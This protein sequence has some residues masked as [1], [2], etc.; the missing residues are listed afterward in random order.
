MKRYWDLWFQALFLQQPAFDE[1]SRERYAFAHGL[2]FI[3]G[4]GALVG[5]A[6]ILR[7]AIRFTLAPSVDAIK[8]TVLVHLQ[9]M[10]WYASNA[11]F[12][13]QFQAGYDQF[14]NWLGPTLLPDP[15]SATVLSGVITT[16]VLFALGWILY[17]L[18]VHLLARLLNG[19]GNL[20]HALGTLS[21]ATAPQLLNVLTIIPG[22]DLGMGLVP[23]WT[24]VANYVAVR[25]AYRLSPARAFWVALLPPLLLLLLLLIVFWIGLAVL[26]SRGGV[27]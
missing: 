6:G 11:Q 23:L 9:Q 19:Q 22:L 3:V 13:R 12:Q 16:P 20:G 8:N 25:T 21:L 1:M 7:A 4:L 10:P 27:S 26:L 18:L 15:F 2:V 17:G 14:W 5:A 24:L